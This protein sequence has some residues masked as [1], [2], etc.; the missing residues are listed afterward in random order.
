[1]STAASGARRSS[2]AR[3][4][5]WGLLVSGVLLIAGYLLWVSTAAGHQ[6][7]ATAYFDAKDDDKR[8]IVFDREV[9]DHITR[10]SLGLVLILILVAAAVW[11]YFTI[12]LVTVLAVVVAVVGAEVLKRVLPWSDLIEADS[13]YGRGLQQGSYPSGHATIA[14][15]VALALVILAPASWR[16]W[17]APV[18]LLLSAAVATGVVVGGWHRPSDA[19]GGVCWAAFVMGTSVLLSSWLRPRATRDSSYATS[20]APL[21]VLIGVALAVF[22]AIW[23]ASAAARSDLP[24]SD[25]PFLATMAVVVLVALCAIRWMAVALKGVDWSSQ[26]RTQQS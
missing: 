9:L 16:Q 11:R 24:N 1:M 19:F 23:G 22:L 18:A 7:D 8:L 13:A 10:L 20:F 26:P 15:S 4:I 12:G 21:V 14:T 6:L 25:V 17:V 2:I 5:G 3:S